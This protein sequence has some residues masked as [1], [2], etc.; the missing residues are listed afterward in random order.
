MIVRQI[1][2]VASRLVLRVLHEN[3]PLSAARRRR[4]E[5]VSQFRLTWEFLCATLPTAL[6]GLKDKAVT[7]IKIYAPST[8]IVIS[9]R[10]LKT[11]GCS[12]R[13]VSRLRP[14]CVGGGARGGG[15]GGG[16]GARGPA[17]GP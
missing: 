5:I 8:S 11:V 12:S 6:L 2:N 16:G 13:C 15:G 3:V 4:F 9:D 14:I 10:V 1:A 17:R 7:L